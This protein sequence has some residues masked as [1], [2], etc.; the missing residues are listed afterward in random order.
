MTVLPADRRLPAGPR[1]LFAPSDGRYC[2]YTVAAALEA[3][4]ELDELR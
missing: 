2:Y 4:R 1:R 3:S